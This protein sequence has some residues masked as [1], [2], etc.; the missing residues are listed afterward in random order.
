MKKDLVIALVAVLVVFG[1][2]YGLAAMKLDLPPIASAP[3]S[4]AEVGPQAAGGGHVVMRV[5]GEPVT[6]EE[7][8]AAF[9][10]V[11]KEM[12]RQLTSP[13]G[14]M[15]FAEQYVRYKLLEQE[16]HRLGA[17][18]DPQVAATLA[19]FRTNVLASAAA[20]K[21]VTKPTDQA[22]R[23]FYAG[24]KAA[25]E[26]VEVSHILFAYAGGMAPPRPGKNAPPESQAMAQAGQVV[27]QLRAGGNFAQAALQLSDDVASAERGGDLGT[28]GRGALPPELEQRV[29]TLKEGQLSDPMP[30]RYGVHI[31]LVRKRSTQPIEQVRRAI[32][33]RVQQQNVLDR[34]EILR[35]TAKVDFDPKFFPETRPKTTPKKPS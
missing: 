35:K 5:N 32:S 6:E 20:S 34:I 26:S 7:F 30:S 13:Q 9:A 1:I 21:L 27:K 29:F 15:A 22:V 28:L 8:D 31:F 16:A 17:D 14:R 2:C 24:N 19:A 3:Y 33:Q 25:F 23:D 11:P 4:T 12:Q 10:Q 18:K